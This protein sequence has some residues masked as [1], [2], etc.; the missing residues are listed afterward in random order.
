ML[1]AARL[2]YTYDAENQITKIEFPSGRIARYIYD[3]LGRRIEKDVDGLI[4]RYVY[5]KE[6]ILL[7]V[8]VDGTA[9]AKY[10]HGLGIDEPIIMERDL[11]VNGTFEDDERF[12]YHTDSLNSITHITNSSGS[13]VQS[14]VYDAFGN[15]VLQVGDIAN[16]YTYTGREFDEES[17]LFYYRAR[18]Y[19]SSIGRLLQEDPLKTAI[20]LLNLYPYVRNSPINLIDPLGL[21]DFKPLV[22][23]VA[24]AGIGLAIGAIIGSTPPGIIVIGAAIGA[25]ALGEIINQE[26]TTPIV[27]HF[28]P[29]PDPKPEVPSFFPCLPSLIQPAGQSCQ[30]SCEKR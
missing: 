13:V 20:T 19:D 8:N 18:Y 28:F 17:G 15:I 16:P 24:G 27:D 3:G 29:D 10:T 6:D 26:I 5:D 7:E 11:N 30:Q 22:S 23:S 1:A 2:F 4:T 14:Y 9:I 25:A 12:Y 21:L